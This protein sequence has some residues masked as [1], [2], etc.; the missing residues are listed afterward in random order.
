MEVPQA[1]PQPV[2]RGELVPTFRSKVNTKI[3]QPMLDRAMITVF[4]AAG[5][6]PLRCAESRRLESRYRPPYAGFIGDRRGTADHLRKV[7]G[8]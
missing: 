5:V 3:F 6:V 2:R 8:F 1:P 7:G 4:S